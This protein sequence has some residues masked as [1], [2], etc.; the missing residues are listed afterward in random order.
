MVALRSRELA[1]RGC[2]RRSAHRR[3]NDTGT[4]ATAGC[5]GCDPGQFA[6]G[7]A[8]N[9]GEIAEALSS[10]MGKVLPWLIVRDA[11]T[12]AF[13]ARFVERASGQWPCDYAGAGM[14]LVRQRKE[15]AWD[16][17]KGAVKEVHHPDADFKP[18]LLVA[19]AVLS[20][21]EIQN[22]GDEIAALTKAGADLFGVEPKFSLRIEIMPK[23][24]AEREEV[25]EFNGLLGEVS[26]RL[27]L[28]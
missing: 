22:L 9:N 14:V 24:N 6:G 19:D 23:A 20:V 4:A 7:V 11:L 2:A 13:N 21:G 8:G 12:A 27:R 17:E 16:G 1:G 10:K 26:R 28:L 3:C 18:G 5:K 15:E 25:E